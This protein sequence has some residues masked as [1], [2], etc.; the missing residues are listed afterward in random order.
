[1]NL[2]SRSR[3]RTAYHLLAGRSLQRCDRQHHGGEHKTD[4]GDREHP[5]GCQHAASGLALRSETMRND[6]CIEHRLCP[7]CDVF[8]ADMPQEVSHV[9]E[10]GI[11]GHGEFVSEGSLHHLLVLVVGDQGST[12]RRFSV[13]ALPA[14]APSEVRLRKSR[15]APEQGLALAN[16]CYPVPLDLSLQ[17]IRELRIGQ[18]RAVEVL[19]SSLRRFAN[20]ELP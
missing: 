19:V 3:P 9:I 18:E 20:C 1:M 5:R 2:G 11:S 12:S 7:P 16:P 4:G 14:L 10:V 8:A 6:Q 17:R 15:D 13:P